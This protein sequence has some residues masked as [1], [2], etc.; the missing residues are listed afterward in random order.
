MGDIRH[1][2]PEHREALARS[3]A[4]TLKFE[5]ERDHNANVAKNIRYWCVFDSVRVIWL[6]CT[7][8]SAPF[9]DVPHATNC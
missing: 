4:F 1:V 9:L 6:V 5:Y 7:S 2:P 3:C 8:T